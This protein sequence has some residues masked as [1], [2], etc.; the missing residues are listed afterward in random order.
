MLLGPVFRAELIRTAR[1]RHYY[2]LRVVY[3]FTLLLLLWSNYQSLLELA[4]VRGGRP[5]IKDFADFALRT[6]VAFMG[7][8][9]ATV[10]ILVPALFGGVIAD[11]KQR[12]IMHYLMA[13]RLSSGEIIL[14]KLAARLL[15]VG[16]FI[17][18][19]VPVLCLL[20][21]FGGVAWDYILAAY[22]ATC[23]IT[24]FSASLA[25]LV[26]TFA[27]RVRQGIL[28]A[29]LVVIAW[30]IVPPLAD[31]VCRAIYP[32][33]YLWFGPVNDWVLAASPLSLWV[34]NMRS[35]MG[36]RMP[37]AV[38][39]PYALLDPFIWMVGLQFAAGAFFLLIAV[40][41]LRPTFRRQEESSGR[42]FGFASKLRRPRWLS[43]P[44]CGADAM[45]WKERHF[46]RTDV[47]TKLAVL[48]A[49]ILLTVCVLLGGGLDESVPRSFSAVWHR[50]Y[51]SRSM[52]PVDL[53]D[54]LCAI[55]PLYI[56]LWLL[57][58]AGASA[59]GVTVE[60]E[61]NTWDGL[62]SAPLTGWE[63]LRGKA[64]GAIW[65][66]RG[67]GG[68]LSL[69]W[70][71]GLAAGAIHPLGL[72][73]ALLV[74]GLLTWFVVALGTHASLTART[75]SRALTRTI[76][77]LVFLNVGYL[78]V[79]YP[80]LTIYGTFDS[81]ELWGFP[82]EI[83]CT[84]VSASYFLLSYPAVANIFGA[85]QA[86]GRGSDFG[87]R[88]APMVTM[89]LIGY[90]IAAAV[91][92][93]RSVRQFDRVVDRPRRRQDVRKPLRSINAETGIPWN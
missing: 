7:V 48:P 45:L 81:R 91:L 28:V 72:V 70:L 33:A 32:Q 47:F 9:L 34:W 21:L 82:P 85:A 15:H 13:S 64:I 90:L 18:L 26:S 36:R 58:V 24:F 52:E 35:I 6:F 87:L 65:G 46:A 20:T 19:G 3:G 75:T 54:T 8:Q 39:G 49:T 79:L 86:H 11:E 59:S 84:P 16:A 55:S 23:S 61:Q 51:S 56:A 50:G 66:L 1:R 69:F 44:T 63:I 88:A 73:L 76:V 74:T 71:V 25:V 29:Y 77:I 10:L 17:L 40:W 5:L 78:A 42:L 2:W 38:G 93:W 57:A 89:L 67:F 53:N 4:V 41:Q 37:A 62:I 12:K 43:R 92:T 83:G 31:Q 30:L 80:I 68:L 27:R 14:D 60:R 22:L